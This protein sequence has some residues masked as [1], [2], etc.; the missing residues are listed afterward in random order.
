MGKRSEWKKCEGRVL[1]QGLRAPQRGG[2]W[3]KRVNGGRERMEETDGHR[4][5]ASAATGKVWG[6]KMGK[7]K[8]KEE[9]GTCCSTACG[10]S[11][12]ARL[13]KRGESSRRKKGACFSKAC[14]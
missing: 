6:K 10:R 13:G 9:K 8:R 11:S 5:P 14:G 3:G 12:R 1:Q 2:R 4:R 7:N